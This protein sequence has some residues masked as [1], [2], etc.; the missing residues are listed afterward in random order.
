MTDNWRVLEELWR[1]DEPSLL[2]SI[3]QVEGSAYRKAGA[4]MLVRVSGERIGLLSGGCVEQDVAARAEELVRS[5]RTVT[6]VYNTR[7]SGDP[8]EDF[9]SGCGGRIHVLLEPVDLKLRGELAQAKGWLER[10]V[11]V[12]WVRKLGEHRTVS[13]H[14]FI[15]EWEYKND[16]FEVR[17]NDRQTGGC[18]FYEPWNSEIF[19]QRLCP[20]PRLLLLGAGEDARPLAALASQIGF[21]VAV[22]DWRPALCSREHFS[23]AE[24]LVVGLPAEISRQICLGENDYAVVMTHH[25]EHD[26]QLLEWLMDRHPRYIGVLGPRRRTERMLMGQSLPETVRSPVGLALG[27]VGPDEI[28]VSIVA[29]LIRVRRADAATLAV[30]MSPSPEHF[31]YAA[32]VQP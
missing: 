5:G 3:I 27:A 1:S 17:F 9:G 23:S 26:K 25:Y 24:Q 10:G 22:A 18:F 12:A 19:M 16:G 2:A 8:I 7:Y 14:R 4:S 11:S 21:A 20:K 28:A 32:G 6:V 13:E 15:P 29:E 30:V 31:V